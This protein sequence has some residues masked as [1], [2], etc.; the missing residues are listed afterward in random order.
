[1]ETRFRWIRP[2]LMVLGL[3]GSASCMASGRS[4]GPR[5]VP[6][7]AGGFEPR[8]PLYINPA[9]VAKLE[10]FSSAVRVGF[11]VYV[12]G[13]VALDSAQSL[14]GPGDLRRQLEQAFANL[15]TVVRA[16]RGVPADVIKLTVY[17]VDYR[18]ED[19]GLIREVSAA[20]LTPGAPPALT[21]V[22]VAA[23]PREGLLVAVDGLAVLRGELPDRERDRRQ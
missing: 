15:V 21:V 4:D 3:I 11:T 16:A 22:G 2:G 17:V 19:L 10:G 6:A 13:Q 9:G 23:L 12:A 1:M 20:L 18:P 8:P 14:V 7:G 5:S